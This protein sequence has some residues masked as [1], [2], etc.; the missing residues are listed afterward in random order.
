MKKLTILLLAGIALYSC[1]GPAPNEGKKPE[2]PAAKETTD[3]YAGLQ[4][5]SQ[6]DT[7]CGMPLSSGVGDT[8]MLEGKIYGFCSTECKEAFA[9][10]LHDEHKR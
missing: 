10:V 4:F 1:S 6:K 9:K 2:T 7:S 3:K 5:A 8:L